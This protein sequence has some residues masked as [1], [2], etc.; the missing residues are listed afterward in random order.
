MNTEPGRYD[1]GQLFASADKVALVQVSS[2]TTDAY[3]VAIYKGRVIK[4]FKGTQDGDIV[5]F[6]PYI[7]TKLGSEYLLFLKDQTNILVPKDK[8]AGYG[9]IKY[10]RVFNEGYSSMLISYECGFNGSDSNQQCDYAV[11]VCTDYIHI[12]DSLQSSPSRDTVTPF[13]CRWV[14][15]DRFVSAFETITGRIE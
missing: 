11:R 2:G 3:D 1:L 7:G 15:K 10:S 5:Y 9:P 13:G 6:G 4:A 8:E 14:R 12:P